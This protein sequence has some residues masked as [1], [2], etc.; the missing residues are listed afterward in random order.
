MTVMHNLRSRQSEGCRLCV[1]ALALLLSVPLAGCTGPSSTDRT[2]ALA[3]IR[4]ATEKYKDV[5]AAIADGYARDVL[6][7]CETPAHMGSIEDLGAMGI[8]YLRNDLLGIEQDETRLDVTGA[9]TDFTQ[10]AGLIYEPQADKSLA[11]VAIENVVS[12]SAWEAKG[13]KEPP[14]FL[15][16]PFRLRSENPGMQTKAQYELRIWLFKDNP[17]GAFAP[18]NPNVTCEHHEYNMPMVHPPIDLLPG[19]KGPAHPHH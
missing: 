17:S 6:D 12:A 14:A 1:P 2:A 18:Y 9:H 15:D 19:E 16:T 8:H 7:L 11:L 5:N 3:A 4:T 13:H 10:P